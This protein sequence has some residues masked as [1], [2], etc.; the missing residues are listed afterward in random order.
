MGIDLLSMTS[1][2]RPYNDKDNANASF[3]TLVPWVAPEAY[4]NIIYKPAPPAF[5]S[6]VAAKWSF[7]PAVVDFFSK[8]NGANLFSGALSLYGVVEPGRLLNRRDPFSLPPFNIED[9]NSSWKFDRDRLLVLGGYSFDGS[10][11]CVD[12]ADGQIHV[13]RQ[14]QKTPTVSWS[15]L[16]AWLTSEVA[17]LGSLFDDEGRMTGL[18]SETGPPATARIQ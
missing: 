11:A 17:R 18:E 8:Q 3:R 13:Y 4:L 6:T 15:S 9:E 16:S 14:R 2:F 5:L 12:R 1:R 10:T 7:P